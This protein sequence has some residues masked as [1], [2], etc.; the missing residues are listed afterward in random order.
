VDPPPR[1]VTI[2]NEE[3]ARLKVI[4]TGSLA[5]VGWLLRFAEAYLKG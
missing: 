3:R 5:G 2:Y 4:L 1:L